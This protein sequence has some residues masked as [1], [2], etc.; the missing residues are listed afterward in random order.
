MPSASD[1]SV[2]FAVFRALHVQAIFSDH[3]TH[4]IGA[5]LADQ[6]VALRKT[7]ACGVEPVVS[8]VFHEFARLVDLHFVAIQD[9]N[10]PHIRR[11][12]GT[13]TGDLMASFCGGR[14]RQAT[15]GIGSSLLTPTEN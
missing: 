1:A 12:D 10:K 13:T 5:T 9:S 2:V 8:E 11:Q 4:A 3:G 6:L 14:I 7:T 15:A